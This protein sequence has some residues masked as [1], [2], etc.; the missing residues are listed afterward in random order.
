MTKLDDEY[1]KVYDRELA[2][3]KKCWPGIPDEK[4]KVYAERVADKKTN[5]IQQ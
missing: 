5:I 2:H 1:Y 3:L 4:L